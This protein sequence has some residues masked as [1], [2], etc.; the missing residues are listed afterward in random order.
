MVE[1]ITS[2]R[3]DYFP[4]SNFFPC[5]IKFN[6]MTYKNAEACFQAMKCKTDEEKL[7]FTLL[8]GAGAKKLGRQIKINVA[9]W[10]LVKDY[11]MLSVIQA[12]FKQCKKFRELLMSTGD[13]EL[14]EGNDHKDGYWGVRNDTGEGLNKLGKIHM[15]I[16]NRE[17][18]WDDSN[19]LYVR[20]VDT[21]IDTIKTWAKSGRYVYETPVELNHSLFEFISNPSISPIF[22]IYVVV[23]EGKFTVVK[24]ADII[25]I[26]VKLGC[27]LNEYI[28]A[29]IK[30]HQMNR[31][32][33]DSLVEKGFKF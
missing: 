9:E 29:Y 31:L 20:V 12:K 14:I 17:K 22:S 23:E 30:V 11:I 16:R 19:K 3:G 27:E 21:P 4:L 5:E 26:I 24:G 6:G 8:D 32:T 28:N 15:L 33:Y 13:K 10:N 25:A 2:F 7:Q 1:R 18:T